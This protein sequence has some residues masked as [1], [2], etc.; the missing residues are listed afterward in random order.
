LDKDWDNGSAV[1]NQKI[2]DYKVYE[3][4]YCQGYINILKR[5]KK[6]KQYLGLILKPGGPRPAKKDES[7]YSE[8][9]SR[10]CCN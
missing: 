10:K 7:M 4:R 3:D 9:G 1:R 8:Q 6:Y 2:P 5:S